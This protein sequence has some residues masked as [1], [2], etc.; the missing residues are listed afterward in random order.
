M[1][2]RPT[3]VDLAQCSGRSPRSWYCRRS[4]ASVLPLR[5]LDP[6][7]RRRPAQHS[8]HD[9]DRI[10]FV[11]ALRIARQ[12][13]APLGAFPPDDSKAS[14]G[15][16]QHAISRLVHR[17]NPKRRLR[18]APRVIKRKMPKWHVKRRYHTNWPQSQHPPDYIILGN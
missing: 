6:D 7:R 4:G 18:A 9:P 8:G 10:S 12:S 1:S 14:K 5:D 16:R 15:L 11:A 2:S 13:I 17:L 3:S